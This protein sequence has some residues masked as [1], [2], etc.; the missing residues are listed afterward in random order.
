[1][2]LKVR[3]TTIDWTASPSETTVEHFEIEE[4][5]DEETFAH[6]FRNYENCFKYCNDIQFAITDKEQHKAYR[7]WISDV[8]NYAANGGD[9]W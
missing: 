2:K 3:K 7:A 4:S 5:T 1:M 6:Y 9:M 8:N